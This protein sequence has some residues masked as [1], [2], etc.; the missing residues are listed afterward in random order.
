MGAAAAASS[1][2]VTNDATRFTCIEYVASQKNRRERERGQTHDDILGFHIFFIFF[3][4]KKKKKEKKNRR[5]KNTGEERRKIF[6]VLGPFFS[7]RPSFVIPNINNKI[8]EDH[9]RKRAWCEKRCFENITETHTSQ[10]FR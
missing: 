9:P 4:E 2:M 1:S 5:K 7:S 8:I 6:F 10:I 3:D